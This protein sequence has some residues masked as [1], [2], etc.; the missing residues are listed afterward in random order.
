MMQK[1]H[2]YK[3][4]CI[5]I[6]SILLL[7]TSCVVRS[8]DKT[9]DLNTVETVLYKR[10]SSVDPFF[11]I[12]DYKM[13]IPKGYNIIDVFGGGHAYSYYVYSDKSS[14]FIGE[15]CP[16]CYYNM[17]NFKDSL[18]KFG[19]KSD[20]A[21]HLALEGWEEYNPGSVSFQGKKRGRYWKIIQYEYIYLGYTNVKKKNLSQFENVLKTVEK[22]EFME[23]IKR[24]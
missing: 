22:K 2:L 3:Y 13:Q 12:A 9:I 7:Q 6:I 10:F 14:I 15:S 4:V 21:I 18:S 19:I 1:K 8:N 16:L 5:I 23:E 24:K 17:K 20:L 11:L